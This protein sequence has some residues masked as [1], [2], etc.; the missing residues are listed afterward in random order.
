MTHEKNL[1]NWQ[2]CAP[3]DPDILPGKLVDVVRLDPD[4][5]GP[6]LWQ[7][8][9]EDR[10]P[11]LWRYI[12]DG[13][14]A[15]EQDLIAWLHTVSDR[16]D[17]GSYA[18]VLKDTQQA[19]GIANYMRMDPANGS[20]EVGCIVL[21]EGLARRPAATEAMMLMGSH[22]FDDL[23]YRRFEWKC[24]AE[25][26]ASKR[27]AERLGF[28]YE[29]TFRQHLVVKGK[30]RDTAWFSMLDHEWRK[31][32]AAAKAWLS[33][34]NFDPDGKQVRRLEECRTDM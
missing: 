14:F 1:A 6:D 8:F 13:P 32:N 16:D 4:R 15:T 23:G 29:G 2:S 5:H 27:A 24:N 30:N 33:D 19:R 26:A 31:I 9:G 34:D 21:G 7:A 10:H 17:W 20:G 11:E 28:T 12:P 22:L 3:A 25:N 18:L